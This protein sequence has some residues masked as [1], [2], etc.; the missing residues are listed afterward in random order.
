MTC[1]KYKVAFR[2]KHK[3]QLQLFAVRL[4]TIETVSEKKNRLFSLV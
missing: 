3:E 4:L 2:L 1:L